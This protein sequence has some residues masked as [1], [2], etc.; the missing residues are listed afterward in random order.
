MVFCPTFICSCVVCF[1]KNKKALLKMI[2]FSILSGVFS[3]VFRVPEKKIAFLG[4]DLA[5]PVL[6]RVVFSRLSRIFSKI[7]LF[8]AV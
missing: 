4:M 6:K 5:F 3:N 2:V 7:T 8:L 1:A